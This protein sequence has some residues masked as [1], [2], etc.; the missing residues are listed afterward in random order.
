MA[1]VGAN[2]SSPVNTYKQ[3][4]LIRRAAAFRACGN[5]TAGREDL[6]ACKACC[7]DNLQPYVALA[8]WSRSSDDWMDALCQACEGVGAAAPIRASGTT[9]NEVRAGF[10]LPRFENFTHLFE[11]YRDSMRIMKHCVRSLWRQNRRCVP[12]VQQTR[13]TPRR[14]QSLNLQVGL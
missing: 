14:Y 12:A 2:A 4:A 11:P 7:T 6:I 8:K 9:T 5:C 10:R 13:K 3:K 1:G